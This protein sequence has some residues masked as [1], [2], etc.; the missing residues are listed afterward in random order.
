MPSI[1]DIVET[2]LTE[3]AK[4]DSRITVDYIRK[5]IAMEVQERVEHPEHKSNSKKE[6][7]AT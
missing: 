5:K 4:H 3:Y 2:V 6:M 7:G 1:A